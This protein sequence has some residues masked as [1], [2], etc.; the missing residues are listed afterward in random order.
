MIFLQ[1][2]QNLKLRHCMQIP[3]VIQKLRLL[4]NVGHNQNSCFFT[5]IKHYIVA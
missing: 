3:G 4:H 2:A 5:S 1:G